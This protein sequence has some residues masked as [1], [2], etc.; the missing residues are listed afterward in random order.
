MTTELPALVFGNLGIVALLFL[1]VWG[2]SV[3]LKD[4]SIVDIVWG[5]ACALPG[6]TTYLRADIANP[7]AL[8]LTLLVCLWA[9]RLAIHLARR[10]LGHGED[11]RYRA[12]R[13]QRSSDADFARWSLVYV[14]GLQCVVAWFVSLPVQIGQV[15]GDGALGPLAFIGIAV[16]AIGFSFESVGDF[17]LARFKKNPENKGK[18]MTEG[19]WALT[20]HPNYFGDA[21]VWAGLGL[22]A[23]EA[24]LGWLALAGPILM[25]HFLH[26][27]SGKALL[28]RGL[29]KRYPEYSAYRQRTSGFFPLPPKKR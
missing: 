2:L 3:R 1:A 5:P 23:L 28:E 25:I 18:L 11:Y 12:M 22:I 10:N 21:A 13:A 16:F 15:G 27:V 6:P 17:Q 26:N 7:R 4:A 14:F 29:E 19:L 8:L 24:P 20:R 9:G